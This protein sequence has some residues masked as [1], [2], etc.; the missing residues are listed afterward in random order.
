[1]DIE[2]T[3]YMKTLD[4]VDIGLEKDRIQVSLEDMI[5]T[6]VDQDQVWDSILIEIGLDVLSVGSVIILLKT[7]QTQ[8]EEKNSQN[9][10][11]KCLR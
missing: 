8:I 7:V 11:N 9:R 5:K 4:E 1:M 10:Y 6:V 3:L 2:V